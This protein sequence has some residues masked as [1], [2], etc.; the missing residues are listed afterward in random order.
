MPPRWFGS[1][2][3]S[4]NEDTQQAVDGNR[5]S[6]SSLDSG[7]SAAVAITLTLATKFE[8]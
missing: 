4:P 2:I 8:E 3:A 7:S 1:G 6:A 5:R